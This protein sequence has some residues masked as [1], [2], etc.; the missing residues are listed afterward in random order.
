MT[1]NSAHRYLQGVWDWA[2]LDGCFGDSKIKP[3]DIDGY[4]ERRGHKFFLECKAPGVEPSYAQYT[5]L[6]SLVSDGHAVMMLWGRRDQP[7]KLRL[8]AGKCDRVEEDIDLGRVRQ[9]ISDWYQWAD[10]TPR[11]PTAK[12]AT[13][14]TVE[15]IETG[16]T[17][18]MSSYQQITI[19]GNLGNEPEMRYTPSG[20]PVTSFNVAVSRQ[21]ST[22]DGDRKEKTT[23]FRISAWGNQAQPC[24]DYLAKGSRVLV[25]G[26]VEEA[27]VYTDRDGNARASLEVK[28]QTVQFLD[29]RKDEDNAPARPA[30]STAK[31][32]ASVQD[33]DIPF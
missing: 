24:A 18:S 13:A 1:I 29:S 30:H 31:A 16:E 8:M 27:R 15:P 22:A 9:I 10:R 33:E 26:E 32:V 17:D 20:T 25:V 21:W 23:W 28:A 6:R 3:M 2:I 12:P 19:L 4:I 5:A 14:K 7:E 11:Q